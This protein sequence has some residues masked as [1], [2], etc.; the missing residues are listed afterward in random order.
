MTCCLLLLINP[1]T[2]P[3]F[4]YEEMTIMPQLTPA[5]LIQHGQ[6]AR[7]KYYSFFTAIGS[8]FIFILLAQ[9]SHTFGSVAQATNSS[10]QSTLSPAGDY[11]IMICLTAPENDATISGIVPTTATVSV[12]G[13]SPGVQKVIFYLGN[14]Y[15]LTDYTTPYTFSFLSEAFT[16][17]RHTLKAEAFMRDGFISEQA[18]ITFRIDNRNNASSVNNQQWN[19]PYEPS[20]ESGQSLTIAATGD[21]ASGE[22]E[23]TA[24]ADLLTSWNNLEMFLYLGDVYGKGTLN[25]FHNWY[26]D[27]NHE[28]GQLRHISNPIVGNH[29]YEDGSAPGYFTYWGNIDSYYSYDTSGWHFIAL[30]SNDA[31]PLHSGSAQYNWLAQDLLA[32]NDACTIVYFHHPRY[33]IGAKGDTDDLADMWALLAQHNVTLALT[34]H[35]HNYQRWQPLDGNGNPDDDGITQFVLGGGGHGIR[36]FA[37]TDS[38]MVKGIDT[39]PDAFGA[40]RMHINPHGVA[41]QY[42]S[43][44][45]AVKDAGVV[46]CVTAP[47]D[48]T[49]PTAPSNAT[50]VAAISGHVELNWSASYDNTGIAGYTIYRNGIELASLYDGTTTFI[51]TTTAL[52]TSYSY[53]IKAFDPTLNYSDASNTVTAVTPSMGILTL[54]TTADTYVHE[55]SPTINYGLANV[56]RTDATPDVHSY[57]HFDIPNLPGLITNVT[58]RVYANSNSGTG[59]LVHNVANNSW[60]EASMTY[61]NAPPS[62]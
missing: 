5:H 34:G 61:Q 41:Y 8:L 10:C 56:L 24:V 62:R 14:E 46:P 57:L 58:L 37:R 36:P 9:A 54:P 51:D 42:V 30:N 52:G 39:Q 21:G 50:A 33:S 38:R 47:P 16:D 32:H 45:Q 60:Q 11:T 26:G 4:S 20:A 17:K 7:T 12:T 28:L 15:L 43:T 13:N 23:A 29:E 25:E 2:V 48:N 6:P 18:S 53:I 35:D 1:S 55:S 40:L 19:G 59:Y 22:P 49:P 27:E 31:D 44:D 3:V